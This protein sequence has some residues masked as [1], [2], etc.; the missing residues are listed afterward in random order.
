VA[1]GATVAAATDTGKTQT[2]TSL[3]TP[4][5]IPDPLL[6]TYNTPPTP[7][8]AVAALTTAAPAPAPPSQEQQQQQQQQLQQQ[9]QQIQL[10]PQTAAPEATHT[11]H[12]TVA[13]IKTIDAAGTSLD[14]TESATAAFLAPMELSGTSSL[15]AQIHATLDPIITEHRRLFTYVTVGSQ[16]TVVQT[17]SDD[18]I[19]RTSPARTADMYIT[20]DLRSLV[21]SGAAAATTEGG[22]GSPSWG[23]YCVP[24]SEITGLVCL[25]AH[26]VMPEYRQYPYVS[27]TSPVIRVMIRSTVTHWDCI[28]R[29]DEERNDW[30]AGIS[31]AYGLQTV[32]VM[33]P[34]PP[35]PQQKKETLSA[36]VEAT[37]TA[38]SRRIRRLSHAK[39]SL[40]KK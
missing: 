33:P 7:S 32:P 15:I 21:W 2:I 26:H 5:S 8:P 4:G 36:E 31:L 1:G 30:L 39:K 35:S 19:L 20:P 28:L 3:E 17:P 25:E 9:Q 16:M 13:G 27:H 37:R 34:P 10:V 14:E 38:R 40:D 29:D 12:D 23:T 11:T 22:D 24:L 18:E 6:D